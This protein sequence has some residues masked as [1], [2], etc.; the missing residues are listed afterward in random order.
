MIPPEI[1]VIIQNK[2][3]KTKIRIELNANKIIIPTKAITTEIVEIIN[4]IVTFLE[5]I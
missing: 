4:L 2:M 3:N 1:F 5:N